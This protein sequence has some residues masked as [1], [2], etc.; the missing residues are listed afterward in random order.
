MLEHLFVVLGGILRGTMS[1]VLPGIGTSI[2]LI[3][4][5]PILIHLDVT[6]LF[7]FYMAILSTAQFTGTIPS[8]FLQ[9]PGESN[10]MPALIEGA[11][12][13]RKNLSS[14]A[15]GLCAIGSVFGSLVAVIITI[16]AVPYLM[17][18][19]VVFL[20]DDFRITLYGIV[21]LASLFSFNN[22]RYGVNL[23]LL[24]IG[25]CLSLI[26]PDYQAG[27]Y[28]YT[29]GIE[30]LE[31]GI[32]FYPLILGIMVAPTLFSAIHKDIKLQFVEERLSSLKRSFVLFLRNITASIRG[33]I[34]G[35]FS[36]MAPGFGTLLSTN[37]SYAVE[38]KLNG[39]YPSR[40]I[41]SAETANNSG[42]FGML[43]PLVLIGIPLTSS[44]FILF[45]YLVEAG[46]SPF[47]FQ[48]LEKNAVMLMQN[49]VPWFVFVNCVALILAWPMAKTIIRVL[50]KL[51]KYLNIFIA[52]VCLATCVYLGMD[53]YQLGY[54]LI[55]L[56]IFATIAVKLKE[57]N[58]TPI[59]FSF[60]LG[61]DL[62]FVILRYWTLWTH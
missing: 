8:I 20:K 10:S 58:L 51:K 13:R 38:S 16:F 56:A 55:C 18:F 9:I 31:H 24:I 30:S 53:D 36:A 29:L 17:D 35:F 54:Y 14:L 46:W 62:E 50:Q 57:I 28:R 1:G 5:T 45:N 21:L 3:V 47:Q 37:I 32:P 34:I 7:L 43:L 52:T 48:N 61:N 4:A 25:Y 27:T 2:S 19:F 33:A 41:L 6:Q 44:E 15:I 49:L 42:G 40:K 22:K 60:I 59:L 12:F 11:K 26:G 23:V 39:N